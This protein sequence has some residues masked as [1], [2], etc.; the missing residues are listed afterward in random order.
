[1]YK[2]IPQDYTI[3]IF[4]VLIPLLQYLVDIDE[5]VSSQLGSRTGT[6]QQY[7]MKPDGDELLNTVVEKF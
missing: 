1:M 3:K 7:E 4:R 5:N 2:M 6:E